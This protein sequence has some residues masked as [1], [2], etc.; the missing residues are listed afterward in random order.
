MG[1]GEAATGRH[2]GIEQARAGKRDRNLRGRLHIA[3][4]GHQIPA[5][6]LSDRHNNLRINC[7]IP[8]LGGDFPL[9]LGGEPALD[10][11]TADIGHTDGSAG[12]HGLL[13]KHGQGSPRATGF[14]SQWRE[15]TS[16]C[17]INR[18]AHRVAGPDSLRM[19]GTEFLDSA[20]Q[21]EGIGR[22]AVGSDINRLGPVH[23][24]RFGGGLIE[25]KHPILGL[26]RFATGIHFQTEGGGA[27]TGKEGATGKEHQQTGIT[28]AVE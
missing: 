7:F 8:E 25:L 1:P 16:P 14:G 15:Q 18:D 6:A 26:H 2:D 9:N 24:H 28:N 5:L 13:W 17:F 23:P 22:A 19:A 21:E 4:H 27:G 3:A 12:I 10:L 20:L 11:K